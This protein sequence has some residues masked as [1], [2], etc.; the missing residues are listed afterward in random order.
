MEGE[1]LCVQCRQG[2]A[3]HRCHNC[4]SQ[5]VASMFLVLQMQVSLMDVML[6]IV[7]DF[8]F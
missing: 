3:R 4:L 8:S 5:S 7:C 2:V 6:Q 1:T